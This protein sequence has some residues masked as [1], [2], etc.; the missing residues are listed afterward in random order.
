MIEIIP[1]V[2]TKAVDNYVD[3]R[4]ASEPP[5]SAYERSLSAH[6]LIGFLIQGFLARKF[7]QGKVGFAVCRANLGQGF[8]SWL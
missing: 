1:N 2:P 4:R 3:W 7:E 5:P 8:D 6:L